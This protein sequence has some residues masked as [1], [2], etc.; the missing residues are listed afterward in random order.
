MIADRSTKLAALALASC[1]W[2]SGPVLAEEEPI[3]IKFA[4]SHAA[5]ESFMQITTKMMENIT[6]RTNGRVTFETY[7]G[8][9]LLKAPDIFPGLANGAVDMATSAPA[10]FNLREFPLSGVALPCTTENVLAATAAMEELFSTNAE[11]KAEFERNNTYPLTAWPVAENVLWTQ[12]KVEKAEDLKGLRLRM[13]S[14]P[15]DIYG[16]LGATAVSVPYVEA[17]DLLQRGGMDGVTS[18]FLEQGV[19]D[20]LGDIV[21]YVSSGGKLGIFSVIQTAIRADLWKELPED[22]QAIIAEEAQNATQ[23]YIKRTDAAVGAAAEKLRDAKKVEVVQLD[24][25]EEASWCQQTREIVVGGY[26]ER[27][28]A[29]NADGRVL[30]EEFGKLI[31]KHS[32]AYPYKP[33]LVRYQEAAQ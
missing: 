28:A 8:S 33:A 21:N 12:K 26:V 30:L 27:A 11:L 7:Y 13:L 15:G 24:P 29:V 16:A 10:T 1:L 20:G 23:E 18:S 6:E 22:I 5:T 19:R 3:K 17:I 14:G 4:G 25:A 31:D 32:A 2:S 9:S